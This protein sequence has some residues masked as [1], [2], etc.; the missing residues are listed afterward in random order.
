MVELYGVLPRMRSGGGLPL[1]PSYLPEKDRI[2]NSERYLMGVHSLSK[3]LPG[4]A[5]ELVGFEDGVEGQFARYN[6]RAGEIPVVVFY[7]HSPQMAQAKLKEFSQQA[8][9]VMKRSGPMIG[10]APKPADAKA[11]EAILSGL[12]WQAQITVNQASKLPPMPNVGGM[13]VA[14]FELTGLLLVICV[15]GGALLASIWVLLRKR[16]ERLGYGDEVFTLIQFRD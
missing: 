2:R 10:V 9:W 6:S 4:V 8:G 15:G 5:A 3:A 16:R 14:I 7:F 1:L 12:D 13:L 11:A